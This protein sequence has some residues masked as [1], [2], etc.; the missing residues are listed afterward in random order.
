MKHFLLTRSDKDVNCF[1]NE[2]INMLGE[3]PILVARAMRDLV[4][5]RD[6]L[7]RLNLLGLYY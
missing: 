5:M 3:T 7:S 1:I 2:R 6:E 4:G